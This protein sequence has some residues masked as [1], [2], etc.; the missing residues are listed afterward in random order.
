[1]NMRGGTINVG[2]SGTFSKITETYGKGFPMKIVEE[3]RDNFLKHTEG[4]RDELLNTN[5]GILRMG[6]ISHGLVFQMG[7]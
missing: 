1:M 7:I 2:I 3:R 6:Q 4:S 5:K